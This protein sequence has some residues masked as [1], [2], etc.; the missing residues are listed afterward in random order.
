MRKVEGGESEVYGKYERGVPQD[1]DWVGFQ[2]LY[3]ILFFSLL[4]HHHP[5][6]LLNFFPVFLFKTDYCLNE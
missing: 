5:L 6:L 2:K 4:H 3:A 1:Q